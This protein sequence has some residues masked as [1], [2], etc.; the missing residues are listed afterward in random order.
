MFLLITGG[1]RV[2]PDWAK[3]LAFGADAVTVGTAALMACGFQQH[4]IYVT[5]KCPMWIATQDPRLRARLDFDASAKQLLN[6]LMV[7]TEELKL[8][9]TDW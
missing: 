3:A 8:R 6:L 5:G 4:R 2:S 7:S 1:L 9:Q